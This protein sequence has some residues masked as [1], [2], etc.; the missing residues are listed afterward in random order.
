MPIGGSGGTTIISGVA[1]VAAQIFWLN[2]TVKEAV[3]RPRIHNQWQPN[4][5]FFE[6][7]FPQVRSLGTEVDRK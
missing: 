1:G 6:P 4:F 7:T 5:T 2:S 3:D